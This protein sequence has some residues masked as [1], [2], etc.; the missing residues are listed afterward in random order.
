MW[1]NQ[2]KQYREYGLGFL[3]KYL[4]TQPEACLRKI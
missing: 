2:S 3:G 1:N 4:R